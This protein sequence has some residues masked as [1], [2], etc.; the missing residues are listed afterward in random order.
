MGYALQ[1]VSVSCEKISISFFKISAIL[2]KYFLILHEYKSN[3]IIEMKISLKLYL[4]IFNIHYVTY[5]LG[6]TVPPWLNIIKL[7]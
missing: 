7:L 5:T 2:E 6:I 4:D 1:N 3:I